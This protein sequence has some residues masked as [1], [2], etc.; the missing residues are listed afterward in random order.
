MGFY[1]V[2]VQKAEVEGK[3]WKTKERQLK[4]DIVKACAVHALD[5]L[6]LSELGELDEGIGGNLDEGDVAVWI[7]SLLDDSAVQPV[8]IYSDGH[9]V[10]I[11]TN[12][13]VVVDE[14][15]FVKGFV[16]EQE[17][18]SFQHFRVRM[19]GDDDP[20]SIIHCHAPA[21][22]KRGLTVSERTQYFTAFHT[23][24]AADR[25]IWGGDFNTGV[26]Q[27]TILLKSI[28]SRYTG[29]ERGA[30]SAAQPGTMS[31][32]ASK[33]AA[34]HLVFSHP[35]RFK[36][37]DLAVTSG[38]CSV[39]VNSEVGQFYKGASDAHDL[40]VAKVIGGSWLQ[41]WRTCGED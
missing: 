14:Y 21:S 32:D 40:V 36:H 31:S 35:I 28:D 2:G 22:T 30:S 27:L 29:E 41:P 15:K 3:Q 20:V 39:Q 37:G 5:V 17:H 19:E 18:R 9:Y 11:V 26:I 8:K 4:D 12:S 10:T 16:K 7:R 13:H 24:C 33:P 38:L 34:L 23:A 6:C 1:N 25:F